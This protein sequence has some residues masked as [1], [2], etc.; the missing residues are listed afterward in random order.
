M[1]FPMQP[2]ISPE[3]RRSKLFAELIHE[4]T[5]RFD[6]LNFGFESIYVPASHQ[7]LFPAPD[8]AELVFGQRST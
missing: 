4:R 8:G 1:V 2:E 7:Y 3:H 5:D 6:T